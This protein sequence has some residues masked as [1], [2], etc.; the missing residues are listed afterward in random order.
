LDVIG[1]NTDLDLSKMDY[2]TGF[3]RLET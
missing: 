1:R 3:V 2:S